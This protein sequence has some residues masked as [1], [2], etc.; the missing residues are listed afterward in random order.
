MIEESVRKKFEALISKASQIVSVDIMERDEQFIASCAGW[1]VGALNAV[2]L[3]VPFE[4]NPYRRRIAELAA[5]RSF[6]IGRIREMATVLQALLEDIDAGLI[7]NFGNAI[8]A[9][10]FDEFLDHAEIYRKEGKKQAA[11]VLAAVVFEDTV[12]RICRD[13]G[14]TEKSRQLE[15]LIND[16]AKQGTITLLQSKQAKVAAHV[17]TKATHAQWDEFDLAGVLDTIQ[18]TRRFVQEHLSG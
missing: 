11:G 5:V 1:A 16:L 15:D 9:E 2:E 6:D 13:K 18:T 10:T 3:A 8:R 12:R 17:R 14:I 7:A 4:S